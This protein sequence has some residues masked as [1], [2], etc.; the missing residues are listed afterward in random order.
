MNSRCAMVVYEQACRCRAGMVYVGN[1]NMYMQW[2][3]RVRV[4][5]LHFL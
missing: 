3:E 1:F 4:S 5:M 2:R